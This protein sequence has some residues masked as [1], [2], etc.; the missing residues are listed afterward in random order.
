MG[1]RV[2]VVRFFFFSLSLSLPSDRHYITMR[3]GL[4]DRARKNATAALRVK[5]TDTQ[6]EEDDT[7][8]LHAH[9]FADIIT[10][11]ER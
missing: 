5:Q 7:L 9:L 1:R 3:G 10:R 6:G 4:D 11:S 2:S 8:G